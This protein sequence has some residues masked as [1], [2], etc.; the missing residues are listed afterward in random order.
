MEVR[1]VVERGGKRRVLKV[2][3]EEAVLGRGRGNAVRIPSPDVSRQHCRLLVE[4]GLVEV[5]DLDSVNGTFV[6]SVRVARRTLVRPGDRLEVGPVHFV[7]EYELTPNALALL[8]KRDKKKPAGPMDFLEGLADGSV[9]EDFEILE[10]GPS[11]DEELLPLLEIDDDATAKPAAGDLAAIKPDVSMD[12]AWDL[13]EG[14]AFRDLL[15]QMGD[16]EPTPP[17]RKGAKR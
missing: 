17:P 4:D 13:P 7:V 3:P 15:D 12:Q 6:N 1:L 2:G 14:T 8:K 10:P 16:E 9:M 11:K 5:E